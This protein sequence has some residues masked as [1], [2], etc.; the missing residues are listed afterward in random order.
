MA[1]IYEE[2]AAN[3]EKWAAMYN[4]GFEAEAIEALTDYACETAEEWFE[5][6][7]DL[8]NELISDLVWSR[9][10]VDGKISGGSYSDWWKGLTL[11]ARKPVEAPAA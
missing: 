2:V 9:V 4:A 1:K 8:S 3:Q 6:W 10:N 11:G 7:R 5:I